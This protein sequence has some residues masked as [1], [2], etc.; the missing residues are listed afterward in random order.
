M[1]KK[2]ICLAILAFACIA[3]PASAQNAQYCFGSPVVSCQYL[4]DTGLELGT[5][6]WHYSPGSGSAIV[7]DPCAWGGG[8]TAAADLDPGDSVLQEFNTDNFPIWTVRLDLYKT[9]TDVTP[10]DF[11]TVRIFNSAT[12]VTEVKTVKAGDYPGLCKSVISFVLKNDYSNTRV[13]VIIRKN[14]LATA[15][16]YVDNVAFFGRSS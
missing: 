15:T 3:V 11:F 9:S 6:Y 16:M 14:S 5:A 7:T 12:G 1:K 13:R 2:V 8:T 10:D 4:A